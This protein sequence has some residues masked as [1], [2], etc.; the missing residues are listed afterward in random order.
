MNTTFA[1]RIIENAV[2]TTEPRWR[3][4]A[5]TWHDID[6]IFIRRGY[7]QQGFLFFRFV[8]FLADRGLFSIDVLGSLLDDTRVGTPYDPAYAKELTSPFYRELREGRFGANGLFFEEAVRLFKRQ[9]PRSCGRFY[10]K[11][12]WQML[13]ACSYLYH[14]HNGSFARYLL[15]SY[16]KYV[17]G[18]NLSDVE[19]L[20]EP[21]DRWLAFLEAIQPWKP[22]KGISV[23]VFD[24]IIGD[25]VEARFAKDSYK[26]D[27]AN[28]H[29]LTV[30]GI[31]ILLSPF[32]RP[33][34][35]AF[36]HG[37]ELPYTLREI[38]K[39]IYT[40][41]SETESENYGYCRSPS[42]CQSC[43][44]VDICSRRL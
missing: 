22:L 39:G 18:R 11:L 35:I 25:V 27:S 41:C 4:Y 36:L 32:D 37:L 24:F 30:T 29:F 2:A 38:N 19:F 17:G 5:E 14:H 40:Y 20:N 33:T 1:K 15:S 13:Q 9:D 7:E 3:Q 6:S 42:R 16:G 28:E 23:N 34:V 43:I 21:E 12:L 44:V 8:P 31:R 26:F 10:W